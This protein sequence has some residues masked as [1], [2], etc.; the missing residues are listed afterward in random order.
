MT[1]I[2]SGDAARLVVRVLFAGFAASSA[3]SLAAAFFLL[4]AVVLVRLALGLGS[5]ASI[6]ASSELLLSSL[7]L[8][9]GLFVRSLSAWRDGLPTLR[10]VGAFVVLLRRITLPNLVAA[11]VFWAARLFSA[12]EMA[13]AAARSSSLSESTALVLA[14]RGAIS[15]SGVILTGDSDIYAVA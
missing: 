9:S 15:S 4:A 13:A 1:C 12:E 10:F 2:G 3:G 14:T 11:R 8:A 5:S 7:S 6:S